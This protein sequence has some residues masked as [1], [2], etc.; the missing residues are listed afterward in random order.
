MINIPAYEL[1]CDR[2]GRVIGSYPTRTEAEDA[3]R[4]MD[5]AIGGCYC[6]EECAQQVSVAG[7]P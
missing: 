7:V 6:C 2:C 4:E 3:E 5:E 1:C